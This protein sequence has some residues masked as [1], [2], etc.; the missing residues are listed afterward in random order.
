MAY[1]QHRESVQT[2]LA[3]NVRDIAVG[4]CGTVS[5]SGSFGRKQRALCSQGGIAAEGP[6]RT[7]YGA[8]RR[9]T[10]WPP[11]F[12]KGLPNDGEERCP[13]LEAQGDEVPPPVPW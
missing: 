4:M 5:P 10:A 9:P 12:S 13:G 1:L 3:D 7:R 8:D 11:C 6:R 2:T